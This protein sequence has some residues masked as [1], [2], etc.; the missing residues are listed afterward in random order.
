[1]EYGIEKIKHS[2]ATVL[3]VAKA[4]VKAKSDDGKISTWEWMGIGIKSL[5]FIK[6]VTGAKDILKEYKD[7]DE[8]EKDELNNWFREEFDIENDDI[9][10]LIEE[11][12]KTLLELESLF[13]K[14]NFG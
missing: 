2:V 4:V 6:V 10:S 7:L 14:T 1:M 5:G 13:N 9:E 8:S 12:F 3:A 11:F